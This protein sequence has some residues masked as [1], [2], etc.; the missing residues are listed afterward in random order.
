MARVRD[1]YEA[2]LKQTPSSGGLWEGAVLLEQLIGGEGC[3]NRVA[4]LYE[5]ATK[6]GPKDVEW[7]ETMADRAVEWADGREDAA[8]LE[9]AAARYADRVRFPA[10]VLDAAEKRKDVEQSGWAGFCGWGRHTFCT[11]VQ[12]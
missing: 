3:T 11:W 12:V 4:E 6:E 10:V 2:G 1:T 8:G 7:R 9:A 5:R